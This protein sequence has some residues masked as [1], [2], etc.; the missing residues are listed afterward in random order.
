MTEQSRQFFKTLTE[1]DRRR[2]A[3]LE[4]ERIG[5]H[6]VGEVSAFY[7]FIHIPFAR[8]NANW[9]TASTMNIRSASGNP[10]EG[11]N[12]RKATIPTLMTR[13]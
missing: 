4:A 5:W 10:A 7:G 11:G 3:A 1:K 8:A 2:F 6:G 12:L 9:R 13:F